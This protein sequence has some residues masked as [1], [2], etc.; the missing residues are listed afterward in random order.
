[1]RSI[2]FKKKKLN[3]KPSGTRMTSPRGVIPWS[4]TLPFAAHV[5]PGVSANRNWAIIAV[6]T[7]WQKQNRCDPVGVKALGLRCLECCHAD[8]SKGAQWSKQDLGL[9]HISQDTCGTGPVLCCS[10]PLPPYM[11]CCSRCAV[12]SAK[13]TS[14]SQ[15]QQFRYVTIRKRGLTLECISS[16]R[17]SVSSDRN[18]ARARSFW[19]TVVK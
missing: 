10:P 16:W 3:W 4:V 1:M 6:E 8:S 18:A 7:H 12:S 9:L 11:C 13:L 15:Q 14:V 2:V 17:E 5:P 19:M